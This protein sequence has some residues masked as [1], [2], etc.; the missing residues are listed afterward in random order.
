MPI[1]WSIPNPHPTRPSDQDQ[2]L[3]PAPA[4]WVIIDHRRDVCLGL[5]ASEELARSWANVY[6]ME[7]VVDR[8]GIT[9][10]ARALQ[11]DLP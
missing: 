10:E 7:G 1:Y 8:D 3:G 2:D 11:V 9:V 4:I 5:F 6:A